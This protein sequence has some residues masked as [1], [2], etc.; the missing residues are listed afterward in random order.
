[1]IHGA[2]HAD[3]AET[4]LFFDVV[5]LEHGARVREQALLEAAKENERELQALCRVQA[6]QR[7]LGALVVVVGIGNE[8]SMVEKLIKRFAAVARVGS[9][10]DQLAQV[11]DARESFGR[12]F[13]FEQLDVAGAVDEEFQGSADG[14]VDLGLE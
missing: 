12:V 9:G 2:G 8:G 10:I 5:G 13:G 11:F 3:V 6:H 7:D 14:S 1:M 4:A